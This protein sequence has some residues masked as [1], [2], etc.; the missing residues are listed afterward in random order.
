MQCDVEG[1]FS[2]PNPT[3]RRH[4]CFRTGRHPPGLEILAFPCNQF[5]AQEPWSNDESLVAE[6]TCTRF[7]A[8]PGHLGQG[9]K[10]WKYSV[11]NRIR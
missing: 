1:L 11:R 6:F 2:T 8:D 7:K 3:L 5:G 10:C 4:G 9:M